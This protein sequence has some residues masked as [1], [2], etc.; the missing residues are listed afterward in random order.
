MSGS[1]AVPV[2]DAIVVAGGRGRRL[3][4]KDKPAM[5]LAGRTLLDT[6]I[7][8]A[9]AARTI[10]VVGPRRPVGRAVRW[11]RE[12]PAGGGPLAALAAGLRA[13]PPGSDVVAV[14]AAD[15]PAIEAGTIHALLRAIDEANG[16]D[17][18]VAVDSTGRPQPLLAAYR[19]AALGRALATVGEPHGQPMRRLLE[20]LDLASLEVGSAA[21]DIDTPGDLARWQEGR[22]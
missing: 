11:A 22:P 16:A 8:A 19:T 1:G 13:L 2:W 17:G 12:E 18:V 20:T 6:A 14:L 21:E 9:R 3:G 15:L 5:E 4:G 7:D 10:V